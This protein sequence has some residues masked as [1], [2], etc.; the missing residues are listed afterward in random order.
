MTYQEALDWLYS[1]QTFGIKLGLD[2]PRKLLRQFLAFPKSG[3]K[4]IHVAGTN[5]KGS[6]CAFIDSLCR[7]SAHRT[8]LFTSP[9]LVDYR[10]RIR[11]NGEMIP[12]ET[13]AEYL[14]E[15]R[16][17]VAE[18]EHHPTFFELTLAVAMRHFRETECEVIV[19]ETGMGGRLDAT[20]AV[21]ADVAVIT[22]IALDH[23]QWLG[24]TLEKVAFEKAGI[25]LEDKP[26]ISAKQEREAAIVIA[27]QA[28]EMRSPLTVIEA[29]LTGYSLSLAGPHQAYN[30]HLALEAANAI[31]I[32]LNFDSVQYAMSHTN[33]PGRFETVSDSPTIIIDGAH[34]PHAAA[35]LLQTWE[36]QFGSKKPIMLFGAVES[37]DVSGALKLLCQLPSELHLVKINTARGLPTETLL[38]ALPEDCPPHTE[39]DSLQSALD[40]VIPA[41]VE[42]GTPILISGSLFLIGEAKSILQGGSFQASTQ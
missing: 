16:E 25:I 28:N 23:S 40:V 11:V 27:E 32:P 15:L 39:H 35:A 37:K 4:V 26:T 22:P 31:G 34:N 12:E 42:S 36:H 17:L 3:V 29:P 38:E 6:T 21:P 7:S 1:T 10:E 24:D 8:G 30:A 18:W 19:L 33:W 9:H 2:G 41:A 13:V 14:T 20:T 5:G